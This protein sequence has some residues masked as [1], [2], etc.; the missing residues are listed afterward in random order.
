MKQ[1]VEDKDHDWQAQTNMQL[2]L[3]ELVFTQIILAVDPLARSMM[4][5][6]W[7]NIPTS[8]NHPYG[9]QE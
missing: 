6:Y 1:K 8:S 2:I 3:D 9:Y 5:S 4:K 7:S